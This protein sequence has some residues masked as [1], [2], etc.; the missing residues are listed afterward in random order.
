MSR[1]SATAKNQ[2]TKEKMITTRRQFLTAAT[3]VAASVVFPSAYGAAYPDKPVTIIVAYPPGGQ[4]DVAARIAAQGLTS[5]FNQSVI[6]ENRA[7]ASGIIGA[8]VA[9]KSAADGY[10]FLLV[11]INHSILTALKPNMPYNLEKDFAP[12]GM[13]AA[14]PIILVTNPSLPFSS[15]MDLITYAKANPN[16][17][18]YGSSGAG[19]GTHLAAELFCNL[20]G[21]KMLHV[22]YKGSAPAITDL[23]GGHVQ[24][25]FADSPSAL[26]HIKTGKLRALGISSRARSPV[27]P[28]L[29]T[30]DE[31][32]V[33][34]YEANS[35]V[36]LAAPAGT[37]A[38]II[39]K[40]SADLAHSLNDPALKARLLAIGGEPMPGSAQQFG[41][42]IQTENAKWAK[43]AKEGNMP[44]LE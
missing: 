13:V 32:G 8:Q 11:A 10:T 22:P 34:G 30:I 7:G 23:L 12:V 40:V 26:P 28:D 16:K 20:T 33:R 9:A 4:N 37:P 18:T 31:A 15:V 25:M 42:F 38:A 29:P 5:H 14:F 3:S 2:E 35:W 44:P 19:G 24:L 17:L 43:I 21:V 1:L 27:V 36:G 6:V 39:N 41:A